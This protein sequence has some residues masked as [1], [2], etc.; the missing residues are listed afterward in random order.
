MTHA[1][2]LLVPTSSPRKQVAAEAD[3]DGDGRELRLALA[4]I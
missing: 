2:T 4:T 3:D 1:L